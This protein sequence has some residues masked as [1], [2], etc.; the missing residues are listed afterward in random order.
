MVFLLILGT[1]IYVYIYI[2]DLIYVY[3]FRKTKDK[4][5]KNVTERPVHRSEFEWAV[6]ELQI[7]LGVDHRVLNNAE[8]FC[9]FVKQFAKSVAEIPLK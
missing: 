8:E 1:Y 9:L 5:K 3:I 7:L 2:G 4:T 6:T